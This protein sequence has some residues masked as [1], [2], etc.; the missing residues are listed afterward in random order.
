MPGDSTLRVVKNEKALPPSGRPGDFYFTQGMLYVVCLDGHLAPLLDV[1][2]IKII[3]DGPRGD[4]GD[5]GPQGPP[6]KDSK[7]GRSIQGPMGLP[8]NTGPRGPMGFGATG[9]TGPM[10]PTGATGL[11]ATG[12]QGPKGDLGDVTIVGDKELQE[13]INRLKA[14]QARMQAAIAN[15]LER[16]EKYGRAHRTILKAE[17]TRIHQETEHG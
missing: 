10:G 13:A 6:G 12:P 3:G 4:K 5:I 16:A 14:K 15:A 1:L 8:G 17:I 9:T 7:D 2:T 11:G